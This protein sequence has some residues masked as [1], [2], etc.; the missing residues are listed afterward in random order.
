MQLPIRIDEESGEGLQLQIFEQIRSLISDGRLKPGTPLPASRV[1]ASD[2]DVS[3]NT[4]VLAYEQ[5]VSEGFLEVRQP[6]GTFVSSNVIPDSPATPGA[7]PADEHN[8]AADSLRKRLVFHGQSHVVTSPYANPVPYDFWVGRPDARLFPTKTWQRLTNSS[9]RQIGTNI[10]RY[11][12]PAGVWKLRQAVAEYA[13]AARGIRADASQVLIVNGI[14][15]SI[16]ILARLFIQP[17]TRVAVENP[18]YSGAAN[19]FDSHGATLVPV[20]VDE[21]GAAVT[22]PPQDVAFAYLTPSHQYPTGGTLPLERRMRLLE[23][24]RRERSYIVE[25]DYDS[26]FYYDSVPLPA[27]QSLDEHGQVIYLGTFSKSLAPGLRL[28]YMIVPEHLVEVATKVKALLNNC[29]PWLAQDLLAEFVA[30]G[31]FIHH[32]RRIRTIYCARRDCLVETLHDHFGNVDLRGSQG[33]MHL[34]WQLAEA[35]PSA[36]DLERRC[37]SAGVGIYGISTGNAVV[38]GDAETRYAR[39]VMLGYAALD[40]DQIAEGVRRIAAAL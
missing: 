18:C 22:P 25:D 15:E 17:G 36:L 9:L 38:A 10:S 14:Q 4:V 40:E 39:T 8:A 33:G 5:L 26:D 20:P 28:G 11:G 35:F 7:A 1:L 2:L 6:S 19:V 32:L 13:G 34:V 29:C 30:S 12:E 24:A 31:A 27:L 37:R 3:R 16:N 23:W 21:H